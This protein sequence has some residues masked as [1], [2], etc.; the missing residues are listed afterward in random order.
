MPDHQLTLVLW[1][2]DRPFPQISCCS[3]LGPREAAADAADATLL[4]CWGW[5]AHNKE[6]CFWE[7]DVANDFVA[8]S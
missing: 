7:Q 3:L 8:P 1:G 2:A 6:A 5:G 4:V